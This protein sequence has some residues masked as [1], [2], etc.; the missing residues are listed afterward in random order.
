[1]EYIKKTRRVDVQEMLLFM[2]TSI[3][4]TTYVGRRPYSSGV[5]TIHIETIL[6][7]ITTP[8]ATVGVVLSFVSHF[9]HLFY[10]SNPKEP[11]IKSRGVLLSLEG[12]RTLK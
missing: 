7:V 2:E 9:L 8:T 12:H 6:L 11:T 4:A 10:L 5:E 3:P 1:M